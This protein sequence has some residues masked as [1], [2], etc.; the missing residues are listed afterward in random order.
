MLYVK[1][2]ELMTSLSTVIGRETNMSKSTNTG[3][4]IL[5]Q[6]SGTK[7]RNLKLK[8]QLLT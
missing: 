4:G 7:K 1:D 2:E 5:C 8:S 3:D 6:I